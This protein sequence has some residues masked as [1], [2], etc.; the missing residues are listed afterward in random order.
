MFGFN[1]NVRIQKQRSPDSNAATVPIQLRQGSDKVSTKCDKVRGERG[2]Q[3]EHLASYT[4]RRASAR[5]VYG[6]ITLFYYPE[7]WSAT[8]C[9]Q[10]LAVA[11]Q[12]T[13]APLEA[14]VQTVYV[15]LKRVRIEILA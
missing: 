9:K 11:W 5:R 14:G 12:Q 6:C 7:G 2:K 3:G 8:M 4:Q 15:V 13:R 10:V 1:A